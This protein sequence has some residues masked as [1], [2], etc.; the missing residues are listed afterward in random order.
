MSKRRGPARGQRGDGA[1]PAR[2]RGRGNSPALST[3]NLK[4]P[5]VHPASIPSDPVAARRRM[6]LIASVSRSSGLEKD[7]DDLKNHTIQEEYR[8]FIQEKLDEVM[9]ARCRIHSESESEKKLRVDNQENVLILFRKLREGVASSSRNDAFAMEAYETSLHL[10]VLFESPKQTTSIIPHLFATDP[11][12]IPKPTIYS[13]LGSLLYFLVVPYPSQSRYHEHLDSVPRSLL[14]RKSELFLWLSSLTKSLRMRNYAKFAA[15][16]QKAIIVQFI[17]SFREL[18]ETKTEGAHKVDKLG[19]EA[20]LFFMDALRQKAAESSWTIVRSAYRELWLDYES[21]KTWL[22]R[23]LCLDSIQDD[24]PSVKIE[25]WMR[26]RVSMGHMRP[27]DGVEGRWIVCKASACLKLRKLEFKISKTRLLLARLAQERYSL[28]YRINCVNDHLSSRL[29]PEIVSRIFVLCV[30][31]HM[32]I[33]VMFEDKGPSVPL[34]IGAVCKRWR[35]IAWSTPDLWTTLQFHLDLGV[36]PQQQKRLDECL[37]RSGELPLS[38]HLG[39]KSLAGTISAFYPFIDTVNQQSHRWKGL[40]IYLP[41]P[42]VSRLQVHNMTP[43]VLENLWVFPAVGVDPELG[44][45]SDGLLMGPKIHSP[46]IIDI[47]AIRFESI[48]IKWNNATS[49]QLSQI[50]LSECLHFF[51]SAPSLI[52]CTLHS[53]TEDSLHIA[54]PSTST[55]LHQLRR[56]EIEDSSWSISEALVDRLLLPALDDF[57]VHAC[58]AESLRSLFIRSNSP[59]RTLAISE[60]DVGDGLLVRVC[61]IIPSLEYLHILGDC[62][63]FDDFFQ[64]LGATSSIPEDGGQTFLPKLRAIQ[65]SGIRGYNWA[66]ICKIFD[67]RAV[68]EE[69][70]RRALVVSLDVCSRD[71]DEFIDETVISDILEVIAEGVSLTITDG[72]TSSDL[73]T[74][75][76]E[77]HEALHK[78]EQGREDE[79]SDRAIEDN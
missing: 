25:D 13:I 10:S 36:L 72:D 1:W 4:Q 6:H 30:P 8:E 22:P 29:P 73:I 56:L 49:V 58:S 76:Q 70:K 66:S 57:E 32:D 27:K 26:S 28:K 23:S 69:G 40:Y 15:L 45:R 59:I 35:E 41:H 48:N 65:V 11:P 46:K 54:V 34:L 53:L 16:A 5:Q 42:L 19:L 52:Y 21:T 37:A 47:G 74:M 38:I 55:V 67:S 18:H 14:S 68:S 63:F 17:D 3:A 60:T 78:N 64:H 51:S 75:S 61:Q 7:G 31:D 62:G 33:N 43:P 2:S 44:D 39:I 9:S 77:Y 12:L 50:S 24:R 20:V 71:E 79:N